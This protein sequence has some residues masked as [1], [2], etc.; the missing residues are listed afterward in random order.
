MQTHTLS[1]DT[2]CRK[3]RRKPAGSP[4]HSDDAKQRFAHRDY[5]PT[6]PR[7][8]GSEQGEEVEE[9]EGRGGGGGGGAA[10]VSFFSH[11]RRG[12]LFFFLRRAAAFTPKQ[13]EAQVHKHT[14]E[15][16][17]SEELGECG[18]TG[19]VGGG[20]WGGGGSGGWSAT[21]PDH[22]G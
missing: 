22:G 17:F 14:P 21:H 20:G 7:E 15:E 3:Y 4:L 8:T 11:S 2:C 12:V 6:T 18:G 19:W 1:V 9:R 10:T 5:G 16:A 13:R